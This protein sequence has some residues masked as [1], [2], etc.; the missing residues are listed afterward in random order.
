MCI[1]GDGGLPER[2]I[3]HHIGSLASYTGQR[4]KRAAL[5][6]NASPVVPKQYG[7][8]LD[9]V[10]GFGVVKAN[11]ADVLLKTRHAETV[12]RSG[13]SGNAKQRSGRPV[14]R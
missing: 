10:F 3:Q 11:G 14:D 1:H 8:G 5:P 4:L 13:C 2:R 12:D 7:A 6:R 9:D